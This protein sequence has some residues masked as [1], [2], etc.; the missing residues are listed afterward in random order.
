[1]L[2]LL[3]LCLRSEWRELVG[4]FGND[5][6]RPSNRLQTRNVPQGF[7]LIPT[8]ISPQ[9]KRDRVL[10]RYKKMYSPMI[11]SGPVMDFLGQTGL[12]AIKGADILNVAPSKYSSSVEYAD[13]ALA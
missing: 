10:D 8:D 6:D 2:L 5:E 4:P 3:R 7:W 9:D 1:M 11:G 13:N 12:D